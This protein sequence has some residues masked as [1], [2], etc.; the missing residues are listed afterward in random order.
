MQRQSYVQTAV[1]IVAQLAD[2]LQRAHDRSVLHRDIKPSN[3]LIG[4]DGQ[5]LLLDFNV[6]EDTKC[7]PSEA[8]IGDTIAYMA[9]EQLKAM[10]ECT[11]DRVRQH[12]RDIVRP[13]RS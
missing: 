1:W 12:A 13:L 8:S 10:L 4:A 9:P 5:P 2:G 11:A 6:S 3:V 7:D